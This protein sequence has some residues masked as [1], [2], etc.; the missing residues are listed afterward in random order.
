MFIIPDLTAWF[1]FWKVYYFTQVRNLL[2]LIVA[3]TRLELVSQEYES[4]KEPTPLPCTLFGA[5][6]KTRTPIG[7]LQ[8]PSST[9]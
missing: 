1:I 7:G 8:I 2:N 3:G 9:S 6:L 4:C 5:A